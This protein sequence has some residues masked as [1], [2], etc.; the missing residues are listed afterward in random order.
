MLLSSHNISDRMLFA[1]ENRVKQQSKSSHHYYFPL[2]IKVEIMLIKT[3]RHRSDADLQGTL[4]RI[5]RL[6]LCPICHRHWSLSRCA[7]RTSFHATP[8][9]APDLLLVALSLILINGNLSRLLWSEPDVQ[10]NN[11]SCMCLFICL[12]MWMCV[13]LKHTLVTLHRMFHE[14]AERMSGHPSKKQSSTCHLPLFLTQLRWKAVLR[15]NAHAWGMFA[16]SRAS[17]GMSQALHRWEKHSDPP[18]AVLGVR[19]TGLNSHS[20]A[21]VLFPERKNRTWMLFKRV[22]RQRTWQCSLI[23]DVVA[24]C[25]HR[26]LKASER[27]GYQPGKCV[28][29]FA[30]LKSFKCPFR[31]LRCFLS[32]V[33]Y[34][35][36]RCVKSNPSG[37]ESGRMGAQLT[38]WR[39]T[40]HLHCAR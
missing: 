4:Q 29:I 37:A 25:L 40:R 34:W 9:R 13:C 8:P 14:F 16:A 2:L 38:K 6:S 1:V 11:T 30:T 12:C 20:V 39:E 21:C 27:G 17:R 22:C 28:E 26:R 7:R 3:R 31:R 5:A 32:S 18:I 33:Q 15:P 10:V 23:A 19:Q 36:A 35:I 24:A